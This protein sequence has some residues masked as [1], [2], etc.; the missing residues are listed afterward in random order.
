VFLGLSLYAEWLVTHDETRIR[1][2]FDYQSALFFAL[3][4]AKM[5]AKSRPVKRQ[6]EASAI[7]NQAPRKGSLDE[8]WDHATM[9][10]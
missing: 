4:G 5:W 2:F 3:F 7:K 9:F 1:Y 10:K 6:A 8:N